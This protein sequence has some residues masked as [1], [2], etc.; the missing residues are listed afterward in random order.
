[1]KKLIVFY[2]ICIMLFAVMSPAICLAAENEGASVEDQVEP[3]SPN[4]TPMYNEDGEEIAFE[5]GE[6]PQTNSPTA[7]FLM[8]GFVVICLLL[9]FEGIYSFIK[10]SRKRREE[11]FDVDKINKE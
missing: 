7:I 3:T 2:L 9:C 1:M 10:R 11:M 4:A 6:E 8:V 5:V